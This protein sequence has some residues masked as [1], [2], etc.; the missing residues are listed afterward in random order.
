MK[1]IDCSLQNP[2][3]EGAAISWLFTTFVKE[4]RQIK[5]DAFDIP[6]LEIEVKPWSFFGAKARKC[7]GY[8][9][10][11]GSQ[12]SNKMYV[13]INPQFYELEGLKD[14]IGIFH[15]TMEIAIHEVAHALKMQKEV[16]DWKGRWSAHHGAKWLR[17]MRNL[18]VHKPANNF[19]R[20]W[21]KK[22]VV[23]PDVY[24]RLFVFLNEYE[25]F[26]EICIEE[27]DE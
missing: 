9:S 23:D 8:C 11:L 13:G 14:Y 1:T 26:R 16:N 15:T 25:D 6:G 21:Y 22:D 2:I 3:V 7:S 17:E 20:Y 5:P 24:C 19:E 12:I 27:F 4:L 18:G 10:Y